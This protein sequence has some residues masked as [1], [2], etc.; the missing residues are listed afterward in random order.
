[1]TRK[2]FQLVAH[3]IAAIPDKVTR[4]DVAAR[5]VRV[6]RETSDRFDEKRF[7]AACEVETQS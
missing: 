2:H 7:L 1:M 4:A 6:F 5:F 3:V